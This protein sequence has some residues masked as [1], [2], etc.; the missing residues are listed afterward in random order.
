MPSRNTAFDELLQA[1]VLSQ[2][3][4]ILTG[5]KKIGMASD[6]IAFAAVSRPTECTFDLAI[7]LPPQA[8]RGAGAESF[9]QSHHDDRMDPSSRQPAAIRGWEG[10]PSSHVLARNKELQRRSCKREINDA[11]TTLLREGCEMFLQLGQQ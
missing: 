3:G 9:P 6:L 7:K 11:D 5:S 1:R 8:F 2:E 10:R 4:M